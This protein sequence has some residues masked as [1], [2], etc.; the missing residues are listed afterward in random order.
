MKY[1]YI[2]QS[3]QGPEV[4]ILPNAWDCARSLL[5]VESEAILFCQSACARVQTQVLN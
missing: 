5:P 1:V 3:E 2:L 4:L